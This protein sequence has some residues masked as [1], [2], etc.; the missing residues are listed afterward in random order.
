MVAALALM[1]AGTLVMMVAEHR[2]GIYL[3]LAAAVLYLFCRCMTIGMLSTA[4]KAFS[5]VLLI[6]GAFMLS[7]WHPPSVMGMLGIACL[8]GAVALML[9]GGFGYVRRSRARPPRRDD[10]A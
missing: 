2:W 8:A 1:V 6:G 7:K 10:A 3:F 5:V 4:P 9:A